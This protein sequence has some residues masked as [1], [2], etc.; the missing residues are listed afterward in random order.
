MV[1]NIAPMWDGTIPQGQKNVLIGI[2]NWL[3]IFGEAIYST[4][5]WTSF[6]EGPTQMGGGSFVA[7]KEGGATDIRFT[8]NKANNMLYAIGLG[9]RLTIEMVIT[10]LKSGSFDSTQIMNHLSERRGSCLDPGQHRAESE[11]PSNLSILWVM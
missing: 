5:I 8:R 11:L 1:L 3:K 10:S 2:G 6:G 4:R 9:G 7:P